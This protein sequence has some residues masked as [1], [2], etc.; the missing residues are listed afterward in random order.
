MKNVRKWCGILLLSG[1]LLLAACMVLSF[2][3]CSGPDR[4]SVSSG[5]S[6]EPGVSDAQDAEILLSRSESR[7][8]YGVEAPSA[9]DGRLLVS[10]EIDQVPSEPSEP[11]ME[12]GSA[13]SQGMPE[14]GEAVMLAKRTQP[15]QPVEGEARGVWFSY[16]TLG[17]LAKNKTQAEFTSNIDTAFGK[18]R[19]SVV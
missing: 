15:A 6:A 10:Q 1:L 19:K 7:S 5:A 18:D 11:E 12:E 9:E 14:Q 3:G 17:P 2:A 4:A 16:L 8:V 13:A